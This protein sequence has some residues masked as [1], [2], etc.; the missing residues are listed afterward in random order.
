MPAKLYGDLLVGGLVDDE[1]G[2]LHLPG[3]VESQAPDVALVSVQLL[4]FL[5]LPQH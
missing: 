2:A 1:H 3:V 5:N 4:A